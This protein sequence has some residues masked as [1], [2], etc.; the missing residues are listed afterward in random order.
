M[1]YEEKKQKRIDRYQE[2]AVKAQK[3][4]ESS[5]NTAR[6]ML[7]V[8]PMGQPI[9]VG[10]HSEK[11]DRRYRDRI[12]KTFRK[13]IEAQGKAEYWADKAKAAESNN[14]ISSDDS[15]AIR[16]LKAKID[17]AE[18]EQQ[19]MKAINAAWRKAGKPGPDDQDSWRKIADVLQMTINDF[20]RIR[21]AMGRD[22]LGRPPFSF[23]LAN[24]NANIARMKKR[25]TKLEGA[26]GQESTEEKHGDITLIRNVEENRIQL[27]FPGKPELETRKIL[28]S[29]GFRWAPSQGAWQRQLNN[30]GVY[31]AQRVIN[32]V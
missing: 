24:N 9:L 2:R 30:A 4:S 5:F 6:K 29:N 28:K 31:A 1:T 13:G 16:K 19:R 27:I 11:R 15:E 8:I 26:Q 10:H 25:L 3:E 21:V 20:D 12:D 32:Q 23:H 14:A 17:N 7:S 18:Q 22:P